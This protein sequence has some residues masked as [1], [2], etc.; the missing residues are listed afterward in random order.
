MSFPETIV[1]LR[2]GRETCTGF[3]IDARTVI[4]A[5]HFLRGKEGRIA[6]NSLGKTQYTKS[7]VKI[8]S[9]DVAVVRLKQ[10]I[11]CDRYY[12][13]ADHN[14]RMFSATHTIGYG[15]KKIARTLRGRYLFP[16]FFNVNTTF[17]T[18]IRRAGIVF[19]Y[20][21]AIPGDSGGPVFVNGQV[22]GIQS[23]VFN[24]K[25]LNLGIAT[26]SMLPFYRADIYAAIRALMRSE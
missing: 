23:L 1:Q 10:A 16:M 8:R 19:S 5:A 22:V 4:T 9:T 7:Y 24:L 11:E 13:I 21:P 20:P 14:P 26:I 2:A 12:P 25:K 18:R 3:L 17:Q 6:V 15:G